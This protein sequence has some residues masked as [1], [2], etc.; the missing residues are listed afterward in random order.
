MSVS[1]YTAVNVVLVSGTRNAVKLAASAG[2]PTAA[3]AAAAHPPVLWSSRRKPGKSMRIRVINPQPLYCVR[4]G[5]TLSWF[6][7]CIIFL[8]LKL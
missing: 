6:G 3:V 2:N 1:P 7:F 5:M 8:Y 4:V